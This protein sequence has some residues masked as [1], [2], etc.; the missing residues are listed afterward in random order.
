MPGRNS[1]TESF[2]EVAMKRFMDWASQQREK[3]RRMEDEDPN[4]MDL[5][6]LVFLC[7]V[8][9][10]CLLAAYDSHVDM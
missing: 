7:F 8:S 3:R 4:H 1:W 6:V 2:S 10:T 9:F 5:Q